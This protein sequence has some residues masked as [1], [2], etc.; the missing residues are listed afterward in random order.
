MIAIHNVYRN[1]E[2]MFIRSMHKQSNVVK[3]H[4]IENKTRMFFVICIGGVVFVSFVVLLYFFFGG[5]GEI[6]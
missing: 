4:T 3:V 5:G 1:A 2:Y 6:I